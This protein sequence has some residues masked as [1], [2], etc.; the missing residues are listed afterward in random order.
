MFIKDFMDDVKRDWSWKYFVYVYNVLVMR[1]DSLQKLLG[2][3]G[4]EVGITALQ[5]NFLKMFKWYV[6]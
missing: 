5:P 3:M 4:S 1:V 6:A 2:K